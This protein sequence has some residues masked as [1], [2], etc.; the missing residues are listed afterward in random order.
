MSIH[1][2]DNPVF[3]EVVPGVEGAFPR[4]VE[5]EGG[6][7]YLLT[8]VTLRAVPPLVDAVGWAGTFPLLAIGPA[9]GLWSMLRLRGLPEATRMASGN[10]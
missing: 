1:E 6:F 9:V 10:R 3:R 4:A 2:I 7:G 8:L 5:L